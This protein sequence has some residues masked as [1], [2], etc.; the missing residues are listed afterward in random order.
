MSMKILERE[1]NSVTYAQGQTRTIQLPRNY[2]YRKVMLLLKAVLYR[3]AGQTGGAPKDSCPGQLVQNIMV[4]ANGR[5]VIK[6][7]D[8]LETLHREN[9]IH[10]NTR[11]YI[12]ATEFYGTTGY[13]AIAV[14]DKVTV[15]IAAEIDFAMWRSI[16]PI[17]SL[18]NSAA[19]ST[20]ELSFNW[21]GDPDSLMDDA[22]DPAASPGVVVDEAT[23]YVSSLESVGV[24]PGTPFWVN[25]ESFIQKEV[26]AAATNFQIELPVGN[27]YRE[28]IIKTHSMGRQ[29]DTILPIP[30]TIILK[31]GTEVF[32]HRIAHH[33][34]ANNRLYAEMEVPERNDAAALGHYSQE[35]LLEGYY[36]L[37]FVVDGR[38]TEMLDT[39]RLSSLTLE[40]NVA[41]PATNDWIIVYPVE[42]IKPVIEKAG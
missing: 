24:E 14:G 5:D 35:L 28:F 30:N 13:D 31:A 41:R 8:N 4:R 2:A 16:R 39:R 7:Y 19:L 34:Q 9:Q 26:T 40:L 11:P 32:K 36:L 42:L 10:H 37:D 20:L 29:V 12:Y 6:Y 17:D 22:Y 3:A 25:K 33:L 23:L 21:A 1:V 27:F 38:L 18:F 15:Y